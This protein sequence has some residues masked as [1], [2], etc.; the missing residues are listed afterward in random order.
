MA[1][2]ARKLIVTVDMDGDKV[3]IKKIQAIE[4]AATKSGKGGLFAGLA[5]AG[6][7]VK[8][9]F[10]P[11]EDGAKAV[12]NILGPIQA[13]TSILHDAG[14]M[15]LAVGKGLFDL[16]KEASDYGS[17]IQDMREQTGLSAETLSS[18][19]T[20]TVTT[21][22]DLAAL[23]DG[24]NK[25]SKTIAEAARGSEE[26]KA[27]LV[28]LGIDPQKAV[29]DLDGALGQAFKTI[30]SAKPGVE[31]TAA[32]ID[33]FG[34]SGA[35][36]SSVVIA[37]G[38]DIDELKAKAKALG[39]Q[40]T[41]EDAKAADDF[42]D[43]LALLKLQAQGVAFHFAKEFMPEVT[44]AMGDV[45]RAMRQNQTSAEQWGAGVANAIRGMR[46]IIQNDGAE[47]LWWFRVLTA[48]A[49]L[50]MSEVARFVGGTIGTYIHDKGSQ[51]RANDADPNDMY[52]AD[53][54]MRR[55][56]GTMAPV[57]TQPDGTP[58]PVGPPKPSPDM[59]DMTRG[60]RGS[61]SGTPKENPAQT[62]AKELE[63]KNKEIEKTIALTNAE[64]GAKKRGQPLFEFE[65][66]STEFIAKYGDRMLV[67]ERATTIEKLKQ[68][69]ALKANVAAYE[70]YQRFF[71]SNRRRTVEALAG[72]NPFSD[73][74]STL[75]KELA[76]LGLINDAT[77]D[78]K[79]REQIAATARA[80]EL[81]A[82]EAAIES[83]SG[84]QKSYIDRW[85]EMILKLKAAGTPMRELEASWGR[86]SAFMTD[87]R[88]NA[89]KLKE[90][91]LNM[92]EPPGP[93]PPP[94]DPNAPTEPIVPDD[95][96]P[97]PKLP[98][99][100]FKEAFKSLKTIGKDA[101]DSLA[102]SIGGLVNQW[103]LMG[104]AGEHA[105]AKMVAAVLSSVASQAAVQAILFTAYGIAALTPWGAAIYGPA[106]QWFIAAGLMASIA[107]GTGLAGRAIA[108]NKFNGQGAGSQNGLGP[109]PDYS[110]ATDPAN[111]N[112]RG[113]S[114]TGGTST[115][116]N[117][118]SGSGGGPL[119]GRGPIGPGFDS[120]RPLPPGSGEIGRLSA[121]VARLEAKLVSM[122][123][124]DVLTV[125]DKQRP[126]YIGGS[127]TKA[128]ARNSAMK[129][130][131]TRTLGFQ[132]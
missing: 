73:E 14:E 70:I 120:N 59:Y 30:Y 11:F 6:D 118:A 111:Q 29:K 27:K 13:V 3:V 12:S 114:G 32:S 79:V 38:G 97:A 119:A 117:G 115:A 76:Q 122:S 44:G 60:A 16:A 95:G 21:K 125:G 129:I 80:E 75:Q 56:A 43:T 8:A 123:P 22:G 25:F 10:K 107:L 64:M 4:N 53:N 88:I 52:S 15:A 110:S 55:K 100:K 87:S 72:N 2:S 40:L 98:I 132:S 26:A 93:T 101:L 103:V 57:T 35:K 62:A 124:G 37:A 18:L 19:R 50:G 54:R 63:A 61:K 9:A 33:A 45:S 66:Y 48:A 128:I 58:L 47:I 36:L 23:S 5:G 17:E 92:P 46:V 127:A 109:A 69:D 68:L 113:G 121:V 1:A 31:Q 86:F 106:S 102:Q 96:I 112:I 24:V 42:G 71:E 49:T 83:L 77:N 39:L 67:T 82:Q 116:N 84:K 7:K 99:D 90:A 105:M 28:R 131:L 34:K 41:N 65:R 104:S 85:D 51:S 108:G 130:D 94:D 126:G 91:L 20:A 81:G 74:L 78:R 89:E